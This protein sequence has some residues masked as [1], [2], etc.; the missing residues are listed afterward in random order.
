M[1]LTNRVV[2]I[3]GAAGGLGPTVARAFANAGATLAV[4]GR[5]EPDLV[6]LLDSLELP[7]TRRMATAVDLTDDAATKRWADAIVARFRWRERGRTR[8]PES[9]EG[10]CCTASSSG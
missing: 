10:R 6:K 7:E 2:A 4:A 8:W 5:G 1:S 9:D 3:A